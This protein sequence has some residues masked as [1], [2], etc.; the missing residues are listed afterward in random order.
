MRSGKEIQSKIYE[1]NDT[2]N[3]F[4]D[5]RLKETDEIVKRKYAQD[6]QKIKGMIEALKWVL[7][8]E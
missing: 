5:K 1:L 4:D 3:E 7:E 6:M 2:Y 8:G